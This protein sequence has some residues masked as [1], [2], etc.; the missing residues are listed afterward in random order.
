MPLLIL[1]VVMFVAMT[2]ATAFALG[3][4]NRQSKSVRSPVRHQ[5]Y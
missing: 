3:S 1:A 4:E 2:I 5:Y